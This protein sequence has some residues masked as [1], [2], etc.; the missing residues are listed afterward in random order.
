MCMS[1]C[2]TKKDCNQICDLSSGDTYDYC[3]LIWISFKSK[4]NERKKDMLTLKTI[5]SLLIEEEHECTHLLVLATTTTHTGLPWLGSRKAVFCQ[6]GQRGSTLCYNNHFME[7]LSA[8]TISYS[9]LLDGRELWL[10]CS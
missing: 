3:Q 9:E 5:K 10:Q 6:R 7:N 4:V 1:S 2:K 8:V